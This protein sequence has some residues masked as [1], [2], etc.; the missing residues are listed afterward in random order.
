MRTEPSCARKSNARLPSHSTLNRQS[1]ESN[2]SRH[3]MA[4]YGLM[5]PGNGDGAGSWKRSGS[6]G[7]DELGRRALAPEPTRPDT[8]Y[9]ALRRLA[10]SAVSEESR[11]RVDGSERAA[12][13]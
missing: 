4:S 1:G 11:V 10:G 13:P 12:R 3:G 2:A 6:P 8:R 7:S 9:E 5:R